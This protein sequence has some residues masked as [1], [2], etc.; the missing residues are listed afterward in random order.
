MLGQVVVKGDS[1]GQVDVTTL[2]AGMYFIEINEGED[3]LTKK[4]IRQ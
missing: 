4:F 2:Q 1:T 3:I